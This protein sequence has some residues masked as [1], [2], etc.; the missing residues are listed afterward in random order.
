[1]ASSENFSLTHFS[2]VTENDDMTEYTGFVLPKWIG[3]IDIDKNLQLRQKHVPTPR[4]G[5]SEDLANSLV[6]LRKKKRRDFRRI[7]SAIEVF[8]ESYYNSAEVS[9]NARILL[10]ASAF[11]ILLSSES[12]KGRE[13]TK[14]F[15]KKHANTSSDKILSFKSERGT[16]KSVI[17][18]GTIKEKWADSFFTLRNHIVHG[19]LPK[20]KDFMF[21]KWQRHFDIA[22]YF[23]IF[24]LKRKI[25]DALGKDIFSDDISWKTWTD[26]LELP[27]K[28][29]SGFEY[30][31]YGVRGL[32]KIYEKIKGQQVS[33]DFPE[34]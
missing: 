9:H 7:I 14:A 19:N 21:G 25:E 11:E 23:F 5:I 4:F 20:D 30:S 1:M 17:E 10:Q 29:Y 6:L 16:T 33:I 15:I 28:K 12:G 31:H 18:Q 3:G 34:L 8:F 2:I 26:D 24:I 22:L 32:E 27:P 13:K